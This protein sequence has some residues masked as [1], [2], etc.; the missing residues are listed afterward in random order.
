MQGQNQVEINNVA[1][2]CVKQLVK[3]AAILYG[4]FYWLLIR[5]NTEFYTV[6]SVATADKKFISQNSWGSQHFLDI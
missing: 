1:N 4:F 5:P 3:S 2:E 6:N